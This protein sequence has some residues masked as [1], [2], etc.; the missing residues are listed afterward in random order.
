MF[1]DKEKQAFS[2]HIQTYRLKR[3]STWCLSTVSGLEV[4]L[5]G[6][7]VSHFSAKVLHRSSAVHPN[8]HGMPN[9]PGD[10][11]SWESPQTLPAPIIDQFK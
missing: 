9:D 7:S 6:T 5:F 11:K 1:F 4:K 3:H 2:C 10:F 8:M